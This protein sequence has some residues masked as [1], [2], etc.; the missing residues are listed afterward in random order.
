MSSTLLNKMECAIAHTV[1]SIPSNFNSKWSGASLV[2][3]C[4]GKDSLF[5]L[6]Y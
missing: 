1:I 6:S 2:C 3:E 5:L 4:L